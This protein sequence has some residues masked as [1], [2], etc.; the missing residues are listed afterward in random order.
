MRLSAVYGSSL[1]FQT[2]IPGLD[3]GI[4]L[5]GRVKPGHDDE[6]VRFGFPGYTTSLA[7]RSAIA[8]SL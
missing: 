5:D 7:R 1:R 2:V 4:H 8:A 6:G 3:P